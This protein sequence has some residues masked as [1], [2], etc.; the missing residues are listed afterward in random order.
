MQKNFHAR[1]SF[2]ALTIGDK[3]ILGL[4]VNDVCETAG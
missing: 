2:N 1:F 4:F 3:K